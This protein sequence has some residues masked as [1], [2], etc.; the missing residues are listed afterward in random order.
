MGSARR[1]CASGDCPSSPREKEQGSQHHIGSPVFDV[2][3]VQ[4][5]PCRGDEPQCGGEQTTGSGANFDS[6]SMVGRRTDAAAEPMAAGNDTMADASTVLIDASGCLD[7]TTLVDDGG[8]GAG[9]TG[10]IHQEPW[11]PFSAGG[12]TV[13]RHDGVGT[14]PSHFLLSQ[15]TPYS[16]A[17]ANSQRTPATAD[18]SSFVVSPDAL[19]S[20]AA[21]TP[22]G[23]NTTM[24]LDTPGL[25]TTPRHR[26][27]MRSIR[28]IRRAA[29][30]NVQARTGRLP[31]G[32]VVPRTKQASGKPRRSPRATAGTRR[33]ATASDRATPKSRRGTRKRARVATPRTPVTRSHSRQAVTPK[34]LAG[35]G[36]CASGCASTAKSKRTPRSARRATRRSPRAKRPVLKRAREMGGVATPQATRAPGTRTDVDIPATARYEVKA[37]RHGGGSSRATPRASHRAT[38]RSPRTKKPVLKRAREMGG[39]PAPVAPS[40][41]PVPASPAD[42]DVPATAPY[43]EP[44]C[45]PYSPS[46]DGGAQLRFRRTPGRAA[47]DVQRALEA[48]GQQPTQAYE[49]DDSVDSDDGAALRGATTHEALEPTAPFKL[50]G[51]GDDGEDLT[52]P[53]RPGATVDRAAL[54]LLNGRMVDAERRAAVAWALTREGGPHTHAARVFCDGLD[55]DGV[56][57]VRKS[58][59]A[60]SLGSGRHSLGHIPGGIVVGSVRGCVWHGVACACVA[61]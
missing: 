40:T 4:F 29:T 21:P 42:V 55:M 48:E 51:Q 22:G 9:S 50:T 53:S 17:A 56:M 38:R 36:A 44:P 20:M 37:G 34:R 11:T 45:R 2:D 8:S 5:S 19:A 43:N 6:E 26:P 27:K 3:T 59:R 33:A 25:R 30:L 7:D 57:A 46:V 52:S 13:I 32:L 47:Q 14:Q 41:A 10:P 15:R 16:E 1:S 61:A 12:Q 60:V 24:E 49:R 35:T 31:L 54:L 39:L 58:C 23:A 28:R 18:E